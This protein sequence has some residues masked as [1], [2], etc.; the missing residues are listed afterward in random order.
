M[1]LHGSN[2]M[3]VVIER[4]WFDKEGKES[5]THIKERETSLDKWLETNIS[6]LRDG[7]SVYFRIWIDDKEINL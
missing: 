2:S 4:Q 1:L 5:S 6:S 3:I 7:A